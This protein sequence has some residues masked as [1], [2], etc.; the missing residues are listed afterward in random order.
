MIW[1]L[2]NLV[3]RL[4]L[5]RMA[6]YS[7]SRQGRTG[8]WALIVVNLATAQPMVVQTF[9]NLEDCQSQQVQV[10]VSMRQQDRQRW[11]VSCRVRA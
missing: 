1:T 11:A 10:Q 2:V 9:Q 6:L 8:M 4:T 3:L 7:V 5:L